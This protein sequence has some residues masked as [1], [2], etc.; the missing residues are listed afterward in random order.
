MDH[1]AFIA[2]V[3]LISTSGALAPGPLTAATAAVGAKR[4]WKGGFWVSVGHLIVELP[5]VVLIGLGVAAVLTERTFSRFLSLIG[6]LF[7]ILFAYMTAR[8]A[9]RVRGISKSN[10]SKSPV[11]V[12]L[13]LSALNPFFI[14]WWAGIG[15]PLIME[16]I[17]YWGLV[18]GIVIL[19]A[20]HVWLDFAWLMGLAK[21][22]SLSGLSL[23][24]YRTLL[25]TLSVLVAVFGLDFLCYFFTESHLLPF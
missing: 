11:L 15:A 6:G 14:A 2:K 17:G 23:R 22:T 13:S 18:L 8:D 3:V 12:G 7:L 21:I 1:L 4:G 19:Y 9:V 25:I 5:L 16:A 10:P 20:A 24:I